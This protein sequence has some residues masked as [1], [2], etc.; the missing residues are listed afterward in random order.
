MQ[1]RRVLSVARKPTSRELQMADKDR[2]RL[3]ATLDVDE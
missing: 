1:L 3:A 2:R